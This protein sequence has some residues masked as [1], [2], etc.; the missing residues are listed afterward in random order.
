[1][2]NE[3]PTVTKIEPE[4]TGDIRDFTSQFDD[5]C[6]FGITFTSEDGNHS[7]YIVAKTIERIRPA[8]VP[9]DQP[10]SYDVTMLTDDGT[11]EK[12]LLLTIEDIA[13]VRVSDRPSV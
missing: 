9:I 3:N 11:T 12:E 13:D 5:D 4:S 1:M 6:V 2:S 7:R 8:A 10:T